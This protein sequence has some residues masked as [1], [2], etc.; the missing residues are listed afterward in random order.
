[1]SSS[2]RKTAGTSKQHRRPGDTEREESWLRW[3][4]D[5][6][7]ENSIRGG[8]NTH[9]YD[10]IRIYVYT[11]L[12]N[13]RSWR[14][15]PRSGLCR[16]LCR[17]AIQIPILSSSVLKRRRRRERAEQKR[18]KSSGQ[19]RYR[20][21]LAAPQKQRR[22]Q[23]QQSRTEDSRWVGGGFAYFSSRR[24]KPGRRTSVA[25]RCSRKLPPSSS[26][27]RRGSHLRDGSAAE[28]DLS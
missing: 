18:R 20:G 11:L 8:I 7:R 2:Q 4:R 27:C 14:T 24:Q 25:E 19:L 6:C 16:N 23:R 10:R 12:I 26:R 5:C 28:S 17:S 1:M 15:S 21:G 13:S 3:R 9:L 22:P